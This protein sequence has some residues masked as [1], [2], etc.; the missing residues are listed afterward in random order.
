MPGL[1]KPWI[2]SGKQNVRRT[3][4]QDEID[5]FSRLNAIELQALG[6]KPSVCYVQHYRATRASPCIGN[7]ICQW[8]IRNGED[9]RSSEQR[10]EQRT[11]A[12]DVANGSPGTGKRAGV[13]ARQELNASS[14]NALNRNAHDTAAVD[15]L[16]VVSYVGYTL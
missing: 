6:S 13:M 16:W 9:F 5:I 4:V 3:Y 14:A 8:H 15:P 12:D 7:I 11:R 10:Y 2:D 1:S